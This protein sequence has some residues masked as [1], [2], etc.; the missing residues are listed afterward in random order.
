MVRQFLT[1]LVELNILAILCV[2]VAV[3]FI[4]LVYDLCSLIRRKRFAEKYLSKFNEFMDC[5]PYNPNKTE[6]HQWLLH[7]LSRMKSKMEEYE[8]TDLYSLAFDDYQFPDANI[9]SDTLKNITL[10]TD[11]EL[12]IARSI[13]EVYIGELTTFISRKLWGLI[14][15]FIWLRR[16]MHLIIFDVPFQILRSVGLI[17]GKIESKI[18][19][20]SIISGVVGA[21]F[22]VSTVFGLV[23]I[24]TDILGWLRN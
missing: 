17:S 10:H 6:H 7:N 8:L 14:N 4:R 24:V 11:K 9:F 1:S 23:R 16:A 12:A 18:R 13:L 5:G 3:G 22:L 21:L 2:F 15:P 20:C 19:Y